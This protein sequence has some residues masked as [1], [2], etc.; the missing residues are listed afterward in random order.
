MRANAANHGYCP[1]K[2]KRRKSNAQ[3]SNTQKP[4]VDAD[5][6]YFGGSSTGI[7]RGNGIRYND[8]SGR[9]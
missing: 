2:K 7:G 8:R 1:E 4:G 5:G 3:Q 6:S 9:E